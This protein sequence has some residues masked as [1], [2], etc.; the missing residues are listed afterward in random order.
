[1]MK[2]R[3]GGSLLFSAMAAGAYA[4]FSKPENREKAMVTFNNLKTKANSYMNTKMVKDTQMKKAGHSDPND[5]DDNRMV[6]EGAMTSVQYYNEEYQDSDNNGEGKAAFPKSQKKKLPDTFESLPED[7]NDSPAK[8]ENA[9]R[10][11]VGK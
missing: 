1:M 5:P 2:K 10:E 11:P 6:E 8:Q 3:N 4:Y 9:T 7:N